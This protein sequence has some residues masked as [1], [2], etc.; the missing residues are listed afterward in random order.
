MAHNPFVTLLLI[1]GLA[2]LVP[3][4]S[5]RFRIVQLP[6]VVGEI[7]AGMVIGHSGL[8]LIEPSPTLEFLAEFGFTYLMFLSGLEVDFSLLIGGQGRREEPWWQRPIVLALTMFVATLLL[9]WASAWW[10]AQMGLVENVLLMGLILSTTSLGI[11]V[12][13]L[14]EKELLGTA[15]GQAILTAALVADFVTLFLL[16]VVIALISRGLTLDL[17][18][19]L[20]LL[21]AFALAVRVARFFANVPVL[22]NVLEEFSSATSQL[23]VRGAFALMVAWVVLAEALGVEVILGA[24]LAGAI[25]SLVAGHGESPL[26]EKLDAIGYGF[27]I[28]IFFI[29][30]GINFNL[31]ALISSPSALLLVP[32]LLILA[33]VVKLVPALIY[34]VRFS[35]RETLAAGFLLSSRLSL[36]IAAAAIALRIGA[37]TE[38]VNA[39]IIFI[40]VITCTL[41]PMLFN[42]L[43]RAV[44]P[45]RR[46]GVIIVGADQMAELLARRLRR[47]GEKITI[48]AMDHHR[49]EELGR[50]GYR[51]IAGDPNK[52]D[53]L[54][55]A[56]AENAKALVA[57]TPHPQTRYQVCVLAKETFQVPIVVARVG[58]VTLAEKL[59]ALGVRVVQ[60]ALATVIALEGALRF[61]TTFDLLIREDD[62]V[63]VGEAVVRNPAFIGIP[64]RRIRLPGN[65]L[66]LSIR[67]ENVVLVPHGDTTLRQGDRV[68]IIGSPESVEEAIQLLSGG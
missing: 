17:L 33:Y 66:I 10:L 43:Y 45:P 20:I 9:G 16:T 22:R 12:P 30:V 28:P 52:E 2:V 41:S 39:N 21:A 24:F 51:V 34:R 25:I 68:A 36:I 48:V 53:V 3:L 67:R 65:A 58:S 1:T 29:T 40:A 11:V 35:W 60:P 46:E 50:K 63:T 47:A 54:R 32:V 23:Q 55:Q 44:E 31:H 14:K 64:L 59:R 61:P 8:N 38:A 42:R 7:L 57:L 19:I 37:I 6:I 4:L 27:F 15:Y 56:G 5:S 49:L 26:R 18:L 13:V 62:E